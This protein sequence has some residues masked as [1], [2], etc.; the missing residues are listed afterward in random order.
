MKNENGATVIFAFAQQAPKLLRGTKSGQ[1]FHL[2][3]KNKYLNSLIF[4]SSLLGE[5]MI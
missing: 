4:Q 1:R 3:I 5:E 2:N